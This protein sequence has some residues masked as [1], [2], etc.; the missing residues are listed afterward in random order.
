MN[1]VKIIE[2]LQ[3]GWVKKGERDVTQCQAFY[4]VGTW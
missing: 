3:D 4:S 1:R 2:L